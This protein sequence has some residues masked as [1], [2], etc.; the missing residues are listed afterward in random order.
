M[1]FQ[2]RELYSRERLSREVQRLGGE[3]SGDFAGKELLVLVIL[4]GA[5]VFAA[6][7]VRCISV[8]ME[9]EFIEI[10]SYCGTDSSG[11]ATVI[12]DVAIPIAGKNVLI[13]EDIVDEGRCL[14]SLLD[15]LRPRGPATL[16]VCAMV[17]NRR[18]RTIPLEPDYVGI[19]CSCGFLVGYGLDLDQKYREL[20][21]LYELIP[22]DE[23]VC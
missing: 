17:D 7:L 4:K 22:C 6:D 13:V 14:S 10:S 8:P 21:A 12:K 16:K 18:R 11:R 9:I 5:F 2:L 19:R 15:I 23:S 20:P 3:I 1:G